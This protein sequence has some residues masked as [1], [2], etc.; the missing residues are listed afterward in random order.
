M[1]AHWF[2]PV[3]HFMAGLLSALRKIFHAGVKTFAHHGGAVVSL[4]HLA[5]YRMHACPVYVVAV[6]R[7]TRAGHRVVRGEATAGQGFF[8]GLF[9]SETIR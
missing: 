6:H 2:L 7:G 1:I 4:M 3:L 9:S 8:C 5:L